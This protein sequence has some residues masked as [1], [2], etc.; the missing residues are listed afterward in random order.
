VAAKRAASARAASIVSAYTARQ[1]VSVVTVL[2]A[3]PISPWPSPSLWP[4][5]LML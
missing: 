5:S 3:P 4:S 2:A 1:I